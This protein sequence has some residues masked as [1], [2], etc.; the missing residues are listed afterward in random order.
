LQDKHRQETERKA[1]EEA[2]QKRR[3]EDEQRRIVLTASQ[4]SSV[5]SDGIP[6]IHPTRIVQKNPALRPQP[7]LVQEPMSPPATQKH[8]T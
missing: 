3:A 5:T 8:H 6:V 4:V 1:L 7:V 2:D